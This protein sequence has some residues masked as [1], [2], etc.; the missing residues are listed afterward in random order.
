MAD[1]RDRDGGFDGQREEHV[2]GLRTLDTARERL[3]GRVC[4]ALP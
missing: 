2:E 1:E 3:G 4:T